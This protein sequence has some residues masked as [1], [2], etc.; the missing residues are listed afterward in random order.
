M[1]AKELKRLSRRELVDV[2]YQLKQNEQQLQEKIDQL[3]KELRDKRIRLSLAGSVA[4]AATSITGVMAAA[5]MTADLYLNEIE[6]MKADAETE[7][8]KIIAQAEQEAQKILADGQKRYNALVLRYNSD[9]K[10]WRTLLDEIRKAEE[11]KD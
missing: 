2:I 7:S 8:K 10:K 4:E 5:Q 9:Y 6:C 3:E 11:K 1:Q